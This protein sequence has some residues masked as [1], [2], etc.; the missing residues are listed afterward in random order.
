ME[1]PA[2]IDQVD[3]CLLSRSKLVFA[4]V[5]LWQLNA[6]LYVVYGVYTL[7]AGN[8]S[9]SLVGRTRRSG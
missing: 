7:R 9:T 8:S 5:R 6:H 2:C 1:R 4:S 3:L